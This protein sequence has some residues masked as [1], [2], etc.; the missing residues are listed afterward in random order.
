[1]SFKIKK[2]LKVLKVMAEDLDPETKRMISNGESV[3]NRLK[4]IKDKEGEFYFKGAIEILENEL[5][6][7]KNPKKVSGM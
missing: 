7:M 2:L 6:K 4:G 1:M 3:L 5:E